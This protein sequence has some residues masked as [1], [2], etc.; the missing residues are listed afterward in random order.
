[1]GLRNG[2]IITGVNDQEIAGPDQAA[3]FFQTLA[4]GGEINIKVR[5]GRGV[6][7]RAQLMR[8]NIE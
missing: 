6:R 5:K 3:E 7:K 8:L 1:M 4:V 2:H